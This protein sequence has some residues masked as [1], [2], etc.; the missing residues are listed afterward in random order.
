[1]HLWFSV[2]VYSFIAKPA[3][4]ALCAENTSVIGDLTIYQRRSPGRNARHQV[5][6]SGLGVY[7]LCGVSPEV[8]TVLLTSEAIALSTSTL[9]AESDKGGMT[10]IVPS[11]PPSRK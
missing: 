7:A 2:I 5:I 9:A 6:S 10:V 3:Q 1:L 4:A 8:V 11:N